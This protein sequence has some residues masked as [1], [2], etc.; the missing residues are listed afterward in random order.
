MPRLA[1]HQHLVVW[2]TE[3]EDIY[4]HTVDPKV[5]KANTLIIC[6]HTYSKC[7]VIISELYKVVFVLEYE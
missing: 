3:N 7:C 1:L 6:M 4:Q 2:L 5:F